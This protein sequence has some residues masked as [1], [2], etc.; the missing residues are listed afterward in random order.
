MRKTTIGT[1][2]MR[3]TTRSRL[4][5][6]WTICSRKCEFSAQPRATWQRVAVGDEA[7]AGEYAR[8]G[9][10]AYRDV[11]ARVRSIK[12]AIVLMVSYPT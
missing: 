10:R 4:C 8:V 3:T 11:M 5:S 12:V 7:G 6:R 9:S 2:I 1:R